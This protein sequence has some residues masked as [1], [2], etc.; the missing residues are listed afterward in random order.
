MG[1][2]TADI[3]PVVQCTSIGAAVRHT[4]WNRRVIRRYGLPIMLFALWGVTTAYAAGNAQPDTSAKT[5]T[6]ALVRSETTRMWMT[7]GERRFVI[8]LAD[9][10]AA[11]AFTS[12]LPL[13]LDMEELN[14]NEKKKELPEPLPTS[15]SRPGKIHTG[16]LL[17]WGARTV[18]V[19]YQTFDSP[20]SYTPLGRIDDPVG[21][22]QALGRG[23]VRV[24]FS[25]K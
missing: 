12:L 16:D 1:R 5:A 9:N 24:V 20:Y 2:D 14:G 25:S 10:E 23:D 7:I 18:V 15:V 19:F 22:T 11:R 3:S 8:T 13:T 4:S 21:L 17:L 6:N